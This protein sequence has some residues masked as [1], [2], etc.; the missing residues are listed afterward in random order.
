MLLDLGVMPARL[1]LADELSVCWCQR[2]AIT[3]REDGVSW[4]EFTVWIWGVEAERNTLMQE[5][6]YF[7]P[8]LGSSW[9]YKQI[10]L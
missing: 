5:R 9:L 8:R 2:A 10:A 6:V 1:T 3:S 4:E 7:H